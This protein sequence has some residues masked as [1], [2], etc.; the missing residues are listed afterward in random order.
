[1]HDSPANSVTLTAVSV[2]VTDTGNVLGSRQLQLWEP[3]GHCTVLCTA[4]IWTCVASS[5]GLRPT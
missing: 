2:Y 1:M 4:Y 3:G 5:Y